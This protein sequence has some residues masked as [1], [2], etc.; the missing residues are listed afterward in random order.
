MSY[1]SCVKVWLI[2]HH[3]GIDAMKDIAVTKAASVTEELTKHFIQLSESHER[4]CERAH[5]ASLT[6]AVSPIFL[7]SS[8][9]SQTLLRLEEFVS[10]RTVY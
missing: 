6:R 2:G 7:I 8:C 10:S 1:L 9:P 5:L 4:E 3:F